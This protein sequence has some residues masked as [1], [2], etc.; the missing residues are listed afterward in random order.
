MIRPLRLSLAIVL[1]VSGYSAA[2]DSTL[3]ADSPASAPTANMPSLY[4]RVRLDSPI[5]VSKLKVGDL[6]SGKLLQDVYSGGAQVFPASSAVQLTVDRLDR[7][8][9]APNDYWPWEIKVFTPRHERVPVFRVA[10]VT[11]S[12]GS[13]VPLEVSVISVNNEVEVEPKKKGV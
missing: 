3:R 12:D 6:V 2:Q 4:L 7:R 11:S 9:R 8:R 10:S 5:K 13:R 1:L